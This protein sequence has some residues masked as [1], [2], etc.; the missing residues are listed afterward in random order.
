[1]L[2]SWRNGHDCRGQ[3][4]GEFAGSAFWSAIWRKVSGRE[5][6]RRAHR[7]CAS[8]RGPE[9]CQFS[10]EQNN[11]LAQCADFFGIGNS[12]VGHHLP[13]NRMTISGQPM[14][15]RIEFLLKSLHRHT[16]PY[17]QL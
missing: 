10:L 14:L 6:R 2:R 1:V 16:S 7:S 3:R 4:L 9:R 5:R 15:C 12:R 8:G 17:R 11:T 13:K